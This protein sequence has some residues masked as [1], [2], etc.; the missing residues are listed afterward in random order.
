MKKLYF[1]ILSSLSITL[2]TAQVSQNITGNTAGKVVISQAYGGGGNAGSTFTHDYVE[3][4]NSGNASVN[5][6]GWSI[7]YAAATG[8]TWSKTDLPDFDLQPGQYFLIQ[9]AQGAGGTTPLPTPDLI[10]TTAIAMAGANFKLVLANS[11]ELVTGTNPTN[12]Q[13]VDFVGFGTANGFEG[14]VGPALSNTTAGLRVNNGCQDTDN[15]ANDFVA[16]DPNPRN[17]ASPFTDCNT[18][19]VK[20]NQIAGLEVYPNPVRGS[21]VNI[22]T[23]ANADKNISVFDVLGKK[24]MQTELSGQTL[25]IGSLTSGVY[26]IKITEQGKTATRKLVVQ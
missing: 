10:P 3:L 16:G 13:I 8:S 1:L 26:I 25:N 5:L 12:P 14:T 24:V 9:Q 22:T 23:A 19:S 2:A 7:Q 20:N 17:S 18:A 21:I 11:T 15:N 4:F 6:Q